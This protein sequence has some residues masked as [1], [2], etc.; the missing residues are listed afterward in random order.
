MNLRSVVTVSSLLLLAACGGSSFQYQKIS[1]AK[2]AAIIGF[3]GEVNLSDPNQQSGMSGMAGAFQ[4][5]KDLGS[6]E[7]AARR[8][9]QAEKTYDL[10]ADKLGTALGWSVAKR[11]AV[12]G[13]AEVSTLFKA[14]M[15]ERRINAGTRYGVPNLLWSEMAGLSPEEQT[16]LKASL[17]VD[18]LVVAKL[19]F[20]SGRTY[21]ATVGGIGKNDLWPKAVVTLTVYDGSPEGAI[22]S[23]RWV[24]GEP[25]KEQHVTVSVGVVD[26]TNETNALMEAAS[27][28]LDA[29]IKRYEEQKAAAL[30]APPPQA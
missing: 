1:A 8:Q 6:D 26:T 17:G 5:M 16:K 13:D 9:E 21:G 2:K 14:K 23:E 4:G 11:D 20:M 19:S 15:G 27:Q 25:A 18:A 30:A 29:L 10:V 28:A 3:S 12:T 24:E 22:W 7:T